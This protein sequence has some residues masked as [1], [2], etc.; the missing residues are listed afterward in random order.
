M[1]VVEAG[2]MKAGL[3]VDE[4]LGQQ[5]SCHQAV[6]PHFEMSRDWQARQCWVMEP[7]R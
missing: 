5:E 2:T 6:E 7:W 3:M 1:I 4:L